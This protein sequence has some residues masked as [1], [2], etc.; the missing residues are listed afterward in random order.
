LL[1]LDTDVVADALLAAAGRETVTL[2][3]PVQ[4]R[5]GRPIGRLYDASAAPAAA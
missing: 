4:R 3:L 5:G 2:D 1:A